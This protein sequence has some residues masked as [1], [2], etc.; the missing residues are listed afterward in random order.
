VF[1]S[2]WPW[3]AVVAVGAQTA[4]ARAVPPTES[5]QPTRSAA[6]SSGRLDHR[7]AEAS[8]GAWLLCH[9]YHEQKTGRPVV[10]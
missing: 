2:T 9:P 8:W 6:R 4:R 1:P 10:D 5:E 7:R 3:S